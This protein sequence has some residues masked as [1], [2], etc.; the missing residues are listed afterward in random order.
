[1]QPVPGVFQALSREAFLKLFDRTKNLHTITR[2]YVPH[3]G[4]RCGI[5]R[6][7]VRQLL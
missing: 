6:L 1:M 4:H 5:I 2:A 3:M 7:T